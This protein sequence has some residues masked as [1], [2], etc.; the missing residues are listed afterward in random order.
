MQACDTQSFAD[1]DFAGL[2]SDTVTYPGW[3][4]SVIKPGFAQTNHYYETASFASAMT[5][6]SPGV[7]FPSTEQDWVHQQIPTY[8]GT[9]YQLD[10]TL[11]SS[12]DTSDEVAVV[13]GEWKDGLYETP[14]YA[15]IDSPQINSIQTVHRYPLTASSQTISVQY[16]ML[17]TGQYSGIYLIVSF[18]GLVSP[19]SGGFTLSGIS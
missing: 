6:G 14:D 11:S 9:L 17:A 12:T 2:T 4:Y 19:T 16:T 8:P 10:F 15:N 3:F 5:Y 7:H 18:G 1:T 13:F